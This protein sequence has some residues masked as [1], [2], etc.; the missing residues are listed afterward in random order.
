M[1]LPGAAN[2]RC[3]TSTKWINWRAAGLLAL[4]LGHAATPYHVRQEAESVQAA[5]G[6]DAGGLERA[7]LFASENS[8]EIVVRT[9]LNG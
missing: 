2:S 1:R 5:L 3:Y 4:V 6:L 9:E 7:A 8:L